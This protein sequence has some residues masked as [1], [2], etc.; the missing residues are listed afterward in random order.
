ME[1]LEQVFSIRFMQDEFVDE[2]LEKSNFTI[3]NT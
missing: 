2:R 3:S 1:F